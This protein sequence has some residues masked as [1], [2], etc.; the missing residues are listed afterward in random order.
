MQTEKPVPLV[1]DTT[2]EGSPQIP[3]EF[4]APLQESVTR[5]LGLMLSSVQANWTAVDLTQSRMAYPPG[6]EFISTLAIIE[7]ELDAVEGSLSAQGRTL[8]GFPT[9]LVFSEREETVNSVAAAFAVRVFA[10]TGLMPTILGMAP[11]DDGSGR[12]HEVDLIP[13]PGDTW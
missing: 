4:N 5:E 10:R 7:R 1:I 11:W 3:E 2:G 13:R 8:K 12:W 9:V 6:A